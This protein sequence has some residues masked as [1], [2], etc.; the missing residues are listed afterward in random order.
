LR[1]TFRSAQYLVEKPIKSIPDSDPVIAR[2]GIQKS[3]ANK[4]VNF[5]FAQLD[6][7]APKG[8]A[9]SPAVSLHPMA[10]GVMG[11]ASSV[12][13]WFQVRV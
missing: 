11:D 2:F 1:V 4:R 5:L 13:G 7:Q 3:T 6:G 9:P 10:A 12:C 8:V